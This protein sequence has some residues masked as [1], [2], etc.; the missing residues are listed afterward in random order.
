MYHLTTEM[1]AQDIRKR[2]LKA[3]QQSLEKYGKKLSFFITSDIFPS[4]SLTGSNCQLSCKHCEGRLLTRLIPATSPAKLEKVARQLAK[5]NAKGLLITGGCDEGGKLPTASFA[6]SIKRIKQETDLILIAHTGFISRGDAFIL[7]DSGLDGIAFDVVGDIETVN[8]VY[9]LKV[10]END[11]LQSLQAI[12]EVGINVLPHV[13]VGLDFGSIRG[14]LRALEIIRHINPSTVI[15]TGLMPITGT[16]MSAVR[17]EPRDFAEVFCRAAE[18]FPEVQ[19]TLGCSHSIGRDREMI[20]LIALE[21]GVF[22]I[23][24]PTRNFVK[25]A[26]SEG[27]KVEYFGTCCGVLPMD[28]TCID[29]NISHNSEWVYA[30]LK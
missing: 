23:A 22:N 8:R 10:T 18:L 11:Y 25:H 30:T 9:G 29:S 15:I 13:C 14:E 1:F 6:E 20:E 17:P 2:M 21:S 24:V 4:V 7:K 3:R 26:F 5:N 19:I 16:P 12:S 28:S 27:Y